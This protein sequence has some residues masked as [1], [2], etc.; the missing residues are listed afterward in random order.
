MQ[1]YYFCRGCPSGARLLTTLTNP[2]CTL[3]TRV[4]HR[5]SSTVGV[6]EALG[7][8]LSCCLT[9]VDAFC[10]FECS[11]E[12]ARAN[13]LPARSAP[14]Q[15]HSHRA[16]HEPITAG[17]ESGRAG[18]RATW[19]GSLSASGLIAGVF[20]NFCLISLHRFRCLHATAD[21]YFNLTT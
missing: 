10:Q 18:Q 20:V 9:S 11:D 19:A 2:R 15:L 7:R 21:S 14:P 5:R 1:S 8:A 4:T 12:F 16:R 3:L 6:G 13:A 17:R